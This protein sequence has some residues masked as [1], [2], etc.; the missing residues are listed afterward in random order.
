MNT[1]SPRAASPDR[2]SREWRN[3]G[4]FAALNGQGEIRAWGSPAS[5][6]ML[7]DEADQLSGVRQIF[8]TASAFAALTDTGAVVAW[9]S[10]G[11][12][13][14]A[15]ADRLQGGIRSLASTTEA[16]AALD[17]NG[18]VTTWGTARFG[19]DTRDLS[20]VLASDVVEI[21]STDHA[22]RPARKM[23]R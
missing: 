7:T 22:L 16:F 12:D 3:A 13:T 8:S 14:S 18:G 9:G 20:D 11:G 23:D 4:A 6:G 15:V 17:L 1:A 19:G 5:G 21:Y 2:S 10:N